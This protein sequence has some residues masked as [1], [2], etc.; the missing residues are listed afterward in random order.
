SVLL[1]NGNG[2]FAPKVEYATGSNPG[3]AAV[4]DLNGDGKPDLAVA[5]GNG[6]TGSVLLHNDKGTFAPKGDNFESADPSAVASADLNGDGKPDLAVGNNFSGNDNLSV[7]LNNGGGTFAANIDYP[8]GSNPRSVALAD[9]NGDGKP[10]LAV[11]NFDGM[12]SVSVL[13]NN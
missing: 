12:G 11:A 6:H 4:A 2:T 8:A 10:D 1:N 9:L 3:S 7:L 5:N 13:L